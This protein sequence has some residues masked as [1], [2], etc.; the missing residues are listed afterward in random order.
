[1]HIYLIEQKDKL[2][3]VYDLL[4]GYGKI[5]HLKKNTKDISKYKELIQDKE[6]K[7]IGVAPAHIDY[8]F[9]LEFLKKVQNLKGI[10]TKSSWGHYIDLDYCKK[11]DIAVGNSPEANSQSVAEY[12][13]WQMFCLARKLPLQLKSNFKVEISDKYEG[14]ELAGKTMGV[15]GLGRIGRRIANI[16]KGLGMN[17][18]YWNRGRKRTAFNYKK[19][20]SL[21]EESGFIFKCVETCKET[22]DL[23]NRKNLK[24]LK[25]DAYFISVFGGIGWGGEDEYILIDMV[26]NGR[27]AGFS[28]EN[29]HQAKAKIKKSYKGNIF[30]PAAYAWHTKETHA[31]YNEIWAKGITGIIKGKRVNR[32]V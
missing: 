31:R 32:L 18:I 13:I 22:N 27:L 7:I 1:M 14:V 28:I 3:N 9:P 8:T 25:K 20:E 2:G 11:H 12:A 6:D 16:G 19:L 30:I 5:I 23:L 4:K 21:L 17:V 26:E 10:V 24:L 15:I 29:D